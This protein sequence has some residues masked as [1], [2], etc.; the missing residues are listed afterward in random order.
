MTDD[1]VFKSMYELKCPSCSAG[2]QAG[3]VRVN[4]VAICPSCDHHFRI[5]DR[6][7]RH[8]VR[9]TSDSTL[10]SEERLRARVGLSGL[11]E[12]MLREG[13]AV[14]RTRDPGD[15]GAPLDFQPD[16]T[17]HAPTPQGD[18]GPQVPNQESVAAT[19]IAGALSNAGDKVGLNAAKLPIIG[20]VIL[21][22]AVAAAVLTVLILVWPEDPNPTLDASDPNAIHNVEPERWTAI[23]VE[24]LT[25]TPITDTTVTRPLGLDDLLEFRDPEVIVDTSGRSAE[26]ATVSRVVA[27]VRSAR[28]QTIDQAWLTV[29]VA[30]ALG[31]DLVSTRTL[32][33]LIEPGVPREVGFPI[34]SNF[35]GPGYSLR[36]WVDSKGNLARPVRLNGDRVSWQFEGDRT[37]PTVTMRLAAEHDDD[38]P[39]LSR[40]VFLITA[41]DNRNR[42]LNSWRVDWNRPVV[43][44]Q[45]VDLL[46]E[47]HV[48]TDMIEP[49]GWRIEAFGSE[50]GASSNT[51]SRDE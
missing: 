10:Q 27:T 40:L 50:L 36:G 2:Q 16:R 43:S 12:V 49:I 11:S 47:I 14:A 28:R 35:W 6:H 15:S 38:A 45:T 33:H 29:V 41:R 32:V 24:D 31:N 13:P 51:S 20:I 9:Q 21:G 44:G 5:E 8:L 4:A 26:G 46:T 30:D 37:G 1:R 17:R 7:V 48:P 18:A 25:W 22:L 3:F 19:G 39:N 34:P 42:P 23:P